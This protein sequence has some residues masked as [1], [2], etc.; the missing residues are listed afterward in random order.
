[1]GSG[2]SGSMSMFDSACHSGAQR[3]IQNNR[4]ED[5]IPYAEIIH[6]ESQER[7]YEV[8]VGSCVQSGYPDLSLSGSK[9]SK[10]NQPIL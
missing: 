8:R 9:L 6:P 4:D 10:L 2:F 5:G 7:H 3:Q 1:M